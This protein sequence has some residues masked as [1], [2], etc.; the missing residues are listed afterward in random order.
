MANIFFQSENAYSSIGATI[1]IPAFD[2]S[3]SMLPSSFTARSM[4]AFTA[5]SFVTSIE[6]AMALPPSATMLDA[7]FCA[8]SR[9]RSAITTAAPRLASLRAHCSPIPLAAPVTSATLFFND[10]FVSSSAGLQVGRELQ[11]LGRGQI[12]QR[13][14]ADIQR[15]IGDHVT[16]THH[17]LDRQIG[18]RRQR[19]RMQFERSRPRPGAEHGNVAQI[20]AHQF[21]DAR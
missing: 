8:F 1:W 21:A 7:T 4:P 6:T 15:E 18:D 14:F 17:A 20:E 10:I 16:R 13:D 2:T 9:F 5:S 12:V 19:V 3:T 11:V